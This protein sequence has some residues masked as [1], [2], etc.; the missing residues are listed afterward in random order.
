MNEGQITYLK[1]DVTEPITMY[2]NQRYIIHCCND[3]GAWGAGFVLALSKKWKEPE[4]QYK[5]WSKDKKTFKLGQCQ[6]VPVTND[7]TV[8]NMIGQHGIGRSRVTIPP[9]RYGA[10]LEC[11]AT[12]R[13]TLTVRGNGSIHCPKF[14]CGLAGGNWDIIEGML[15]HDICKYGINVYVYEWEPT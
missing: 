2:G 1:G 10:I 4:Q 5:E 6:F 13:D 8:V 12:V 7:I 3:V 11:L 9:I 14:G 15:N